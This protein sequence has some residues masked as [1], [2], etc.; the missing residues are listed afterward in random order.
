VELACA[1]KMLCTACTC[2][3]VA[4]LVSSVDGQAAFS[5]LWA[6][7]FRA[8]APGSARGGSEKSTSAAQ[9]ASGTARTSHSSRMLRIDLSSGSVSGGGCGEELLTDVGLAGG[10]LTGIGV[11]M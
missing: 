7:F 11:C 10:T 3:A 2:C 6:S 1:S 8:C 4:A 9:E 5:G